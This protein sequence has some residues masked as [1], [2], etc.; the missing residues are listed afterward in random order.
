M[1]P[2][3]LSEQDVQAI[4]AYLFSLRSEAVVPAAMTGDS[5]GPA[6][7]GA[8]ER[9]TAG[10]APLDAHDPVGSARTQGDPGYPGGDTTSHPAGHDGH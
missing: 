3:G 2:T 7:V 8:I 4:A 1:P 9:G 10:A 6:G 5:A